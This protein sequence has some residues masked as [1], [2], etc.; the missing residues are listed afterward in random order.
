MQKK[1]IG[2]NEQCECGSGKKHKKCCLGIDEKLKDV[3]VF[4]ELDKLNVGSERIKKRIIKTVNTLYKKPGMAIS[5]ASE[6]PAEAKAIYRLL[7]NK[8]FKKE[9][10]LE[11]HK[12]AVIE[13][14]Q[15]KRIKTILC[16]QDTAELNYT[17]LKATE[18]LG[19]V[20]KESSTAKGLMMHTAIALTEEGVSLGLLHQKIWSREGYKKLT[21]TEKPKI[22]IEEK[23]SY[24]WIEA[25]DEITKELPRDIRVIT[26][27][28]REGDIYELFCR[29][30]EKKQEYLVRAKSN[31]NTNEG[32]KLFNIIKDEKVSGKVVVNIPR[33]TRN[34]IKERE[35]TLTIKYK[36]VEIKKPKDLK[37]YKD[38][39]TIN[40][41]L[42][43]EE[44]PPK[45]I[46]PISWYLTTNIDI[47]SFED[48]VKMVRWYVH[49]WKIERFHF[50]LKSGCKVE[51]IQSSETTRLIK[52][53]TLLSLIAIKILTITYFAREYPET[54][55]EEFFTEE[56][57]KTLYI[58]ANQTR[59]IPNKIPTI[60][61]A[62]YYLGRLGGFLG[63]KSDKDPGAECIWRGLHDLN[64]IIRYKN[65]L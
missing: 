4:E 52:L 50:V 65:I 3:N 60:K 27:C 33:D 57:W 40:I 13:K 11:A 25:L 22:P 31:R 58:M 56:E 64:I 21:S 41:V 6:S 23:E 30:N 51:E 38:S 62:V 26:I 9:T 24:K 61:E 12:K 10:L 59:D 20:A 37:G 16:P 36:K 45:G 2:R 53:I 42:A 35:A 39:I 8:K 29:A 44:D 19:N 55:C 32:K 17:G 28:D 47:L 54:T 48:A 15:E 18:G 34:G 63:R 1:K 7:A 5:A 43:V 49:R 46:T 14:I